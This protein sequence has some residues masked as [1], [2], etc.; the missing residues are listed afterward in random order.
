[1]PKSQKQRDT[2]RTKRRA[3]IRRGMKIAIYE[4]QQALAPHGLKLT[5]PLDFIPYTVAIA[6]GGRRGASPEDRAV[7]AHWQR[8]IHS[9]T[10]MA[11]HITSFLRA[12]AARRYVRTD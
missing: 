4:I 5:F 2:E 9:R 8:Y 11:R 12:A 10:E 6:E 1:M 7:A 3:A